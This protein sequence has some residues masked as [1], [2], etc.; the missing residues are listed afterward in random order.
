MYAVIFRAEIKAL[1]ARYSE[2]AE[3][4]R[5]LAIHEYGCTEFTAVSDGAHEIAISYW[6]DKE[7][8]KKWKQDARHVVAQALGQSTW[9]RAYTV[10]VVEI[11]HE[12][13]QTEG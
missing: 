3:Q 6:R 4:L 2:W 12:Y 10:Q 5:A 13:K 11:L 1:D 7:Q 9:Y 8:I